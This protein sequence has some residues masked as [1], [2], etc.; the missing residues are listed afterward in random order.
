[1]KK[2][3]FFLG[4]LI[5]LALF[6]PEFVFSEEAQTSKDHNILQ[7]HSSRPWRTWS[8]EARISEDY[9]IQPSDVLEISVYGE[10]ELTRKLVVRTDGKI[11]FPLI[12]DIKAAGRS[13]TE[14]KAIIDKKVSAFIPEA[15]STV[16]VET[17]GSLKFYVVGE[18]AKPG[19]FN[20]S[21]KVTVLQALSLAGG[22]KTFADENSIK[23]IRGHGKDTTNFRFDYSQVKNGKN[24][25]QNILLERGDVVLVP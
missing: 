21:T 14:I 9:I 23:I 20:V 6:G 5:L 1:M 3:Q 10:S 4:L 11:S 25:E 12:G 2:F 7:K 13:T 17:L 18:V 19:M 16:I 15:S 24:L 8:E 22:L